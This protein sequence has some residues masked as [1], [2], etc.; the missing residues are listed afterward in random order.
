MDLLTTISREIVSG[1]AEWGS[2]WEDLISIALEK[3]LFWLPKLQREA[4]S[5]TII[6]E[7]LLYYFEE[8]CQE[9]TV[10]CKAANI[11]EFLTVWKMEVT[12][13]W[14]ERSKVFIWPKVKIFRHWW[15]NKEESKPNNMIELVNMSHKP[16]GAFYDRLK[17]SFH[18][19]V[20]EAR[21]TEYS[22]W[23]SFK[24]IFQIQ[25]M[26]EKLCTSSIHPPIY[27]SSI[28]FCWIIL[29]FYWFM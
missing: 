22:I 18:L 20:I 13:E 10:P 24:R 25:M 21:E 8:F 26:G 27:S 17:D 16:V 4:S 15:G 6:R 19:L 2:A 7:N 9:D 1:L 29:K 11:Q 14:Q 12:V 28:A 3:D 5:G 23:C